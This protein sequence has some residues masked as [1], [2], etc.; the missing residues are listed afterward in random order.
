MSR[1]LSRSRAMSDPSDRNVAAYIPSAWT[2]PILRSVP[3]IGHHLPASTGPPPQP[4]GV[5]DGDRR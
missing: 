5:Q 3:A 1:H 4:D 2:A